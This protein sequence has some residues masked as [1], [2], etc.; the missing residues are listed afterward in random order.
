MSLFIF[1]LKDNLINYNIYLLIFVNFN[2]IKNLS[3]S[4]WFCSCHYDV[5][6]VPLQYFGFNFL[7]INPINLILVLL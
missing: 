3:L 4:H 6:H 7:S 2:L 5:S 1:G